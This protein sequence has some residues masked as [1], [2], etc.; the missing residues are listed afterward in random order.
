MNWRRGIVTPKWKRAGIF[1]NGTTVSK[2][3]IT[4]NMSKV[5]WKAVLKTK[6]LGKVSQRKFASCQS[7]L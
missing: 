5:P 4:V 6:P 7:E 3:P 2:K 1:R